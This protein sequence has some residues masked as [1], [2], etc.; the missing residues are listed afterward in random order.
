[1]LRIPSAG[2]PVGAIDLARGLLATDTE[3]F[4][5]ELARVAGVRHAGLASTGSAAFYLTLKALAARSGR[6]EVVL[7]AYVAPVVVLPVQRA[8]LRPVVA[9]VSLETFNIDADSIRK[10]INADTLAVMPAHMFG[11]PCDMKA[12]RAALEGTGVALI[13]DAA[14]ALGATIDGRMAGSLGDAGFYSFHRG[15]QI[16]SVMGGAWVTNDGSLAADI[17]REAEALHQPSAM[18]RAAT[19]AKLA[20]FS[21]AVRPWFYS[22]FHPLLARFKD[23]TPHEDFHAAAYTPTQAGTALSLLRKLDVIIT[24][25]NERAN[26]AREM[27]ANVPGITLPKIPPGASPAYNHCPLLLPDEAMRDRALAAALAAN[28]ECTTLYGKTIYHAYGL[29]PEECGGSDDCPRAED[30]ARRLLLIPCHPLIPMHRVEQTAEI[31]TNAV[32][33]RR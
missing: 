23:T 19:F 7:P 17:E 32:D 14:S 5:R 1:M 3:P 28:V 21:L 29:G 26:R 15:K 9:D 33:G 11:I 22:A 10:R 16:S 8:G 31:I 6:K 12:V 18:Q 20:V 2:V 4:R 24:A 27:L 30:L 13:E 25:R